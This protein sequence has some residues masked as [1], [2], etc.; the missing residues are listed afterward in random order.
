MVAL[1]SHFHLTTK[2]VN[3]GFIFASK[4]QQKNTLSKAL[5]D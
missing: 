4:D 2:I 5:G 1:T 3:Q